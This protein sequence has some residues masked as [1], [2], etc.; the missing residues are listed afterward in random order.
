MSLKEKALEGTR[1]SSG[2]AGVAGLVRAGPRFHALRSDMHMCVF[3]AR[4]VQWLEPRTG[5]DHCSKWQLIVAGLG[6]V[7]RT[8]QADTGVMPRPRGVAPRSGHPH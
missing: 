5:A 6:R 1:A 7:A 8:A 2:A 3:L 4:R